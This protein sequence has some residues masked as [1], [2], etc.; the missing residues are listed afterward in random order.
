MRVFVTGATGFIGSA[1]VKELLGAGDQ[2]RGL[3]R[4]KEGAK[5]LT[6]AG[7]TPHWGSLEDLGSLK[8]GAA[9]ADGVI[10]LAFIHD[11]SDVKLS[12]RLGVIA[13][14]LTGRLVST[15]M[16]KMI[17]TEMAALET[18]GSALAGSDRPFV[19]TVGTMGMRPGVV[20]SEE[21]APDPA[22]PGAAR[23]VPSEKAMAAWAAQG[24]RTSVV[25]LP[26]SVH[27]DGDGG[28]VPR[29][30]G[31]ARKKR[32]SAYVGDG[33]NRWPAVHRLDAARLY[34]LAL[35]QGVAGSIYHGAAEIGVP[36]REIAEVI[37]HRLNLPVRS[38]T[39]AE[40]AGHFSFFAPFV[41]ADNPTSSLATQKNLNWQP[42]ETTLIADID[43]PSYF[44][45]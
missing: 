8:S 44:N 30:A 40:V 26:P 39:S 28:F 15:F 18:M 29:L 32:V 34:R 21:N 20:A 22:A 1:V 37:G 10:H 2:V 38:K 31:I 6:A 25:R 42:V 7:A 27:G 23:S 5:R 9:S 13:S 11:F 4:T 41:M 12:T 33:A 16:A 24:V 17:G 14:G 3:T 35:E 19:I 45:I 43:R 36:F